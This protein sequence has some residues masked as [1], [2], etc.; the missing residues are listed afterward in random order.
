MPFSIVVVT[1]NSERDLPRLIGSIHAHLSDQDYELIFVD[2]AS[3]DSSP[4]LAAELAPEARVL[5]LEENVGFGI[6][7]N[8]GTREATADVVVLLNPDTALV[9]GSLADLADLARS[10]RALFGAR[11]LNADGTR[12]I[13]AFPRVASWEGA[14]LA[15]WPGALMPRALKRRAEPWRLEERLPAGWLSAACLAGRRDLLLELGPFDE[16]LHLYGEDTDLGVRA[17]LAGVPSV[18][19]PDAARVIHITGRSGQQRFSDVGMRRKVVARRWVVREHLGR[20]RLALDNVVEFIR[21]GSRWLLK[22]L[23]RRDAAEDGAWV[24]AMFSR[25]Q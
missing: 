11:L 10:E 20:G 7:C 4:T 18:F 19:A 5:A 16:R 24:K 21:H 6:G 23:L 25:T 3:T 22:K 9:D 13:S 1:W 15:I 12:Q 17:W 14:L 8:T 2:S